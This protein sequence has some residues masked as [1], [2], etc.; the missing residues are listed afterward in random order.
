MENLYAHI[1]TKTKSMYPLV[2]AGPNRP[3]N[4]RRQ[5]RLCT[6]VEQRNFASL[7]DHHEVSVQQWKSVCGTKNGTFFNPLTGLGLFG[8]PVS[9]IRQCWL[10]S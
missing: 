6:H 8:L 3:D 7:N 1:L 5:V 4:E 2:E 9:S 10:K